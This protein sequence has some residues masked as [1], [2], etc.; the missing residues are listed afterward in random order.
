M[1]ARSGRDRRQ[2]PDGLAPGQVERR[3]GPDRRTLQVTEETLA[4]IEAK[5]AE[6]QPMPDQGD[7]DETGWDKVIIPVK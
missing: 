7:S 2:N 6:I 5:L 4:N 3:R 1:N